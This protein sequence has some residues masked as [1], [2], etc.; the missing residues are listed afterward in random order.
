MKI[1]GRN[2]NK[3]DFKGFKFNSYNYYFSE[4]GVIKD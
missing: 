3:K 2:I 4:K 1:N